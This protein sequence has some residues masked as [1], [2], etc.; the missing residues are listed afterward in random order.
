MP[1]SENW[2]G[3]GVKIVELG[4]EMIIDHI[5]VDDDVVLVGGAQQPLEILRASIMAFGALRSTPS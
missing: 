5:K 1:I 3:V 2:L 4:A